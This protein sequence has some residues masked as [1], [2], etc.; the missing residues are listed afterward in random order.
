MTP[1]CRR[2]IKRKVHLFRTQP[3]MILMDLLR[4]SSI[5]RSIHHPSIQQNLTRNKPTSPPL[6]VCE[7][8]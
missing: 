8:P 1:N 2:K 5:T 3:L 7:T 4:S 6:R